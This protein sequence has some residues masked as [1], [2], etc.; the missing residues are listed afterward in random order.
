MAEPEINGF[1]S[2]PANAGGVSALTQNQ[3]LASQLF[4]YRNVLAREVGELRGLAR[5]RRPQRLP[6]VLTREEV[7]QVWARLS[8]ADRLMASLLYGPGFRLNKCLSLRVQHI[9]FERRPLLVRDSNGGKDRLTMLP[10]SLVEALE[11]HLMHVRAVLG[12]RPL[13]WLG[14][15]RAAR[16]DGA[17]VSERA[18]G[19]A[20]AMGVSAGEA[21]AQR[22]V[23]RAGPQP[24]RRID[25]VNGG[26][27]GSHRVRSA[28]ASELP[29]LP[30]FVRHLSPR[31]W[32]RHPHGAET[33]GTQRS[34]D[35]DDL[36]LCAESRRPGREEHSGRCASRRRET[37]C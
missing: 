34:A 23:R 37:L 21:L 18:G 14:A 1:L 5:A 32:L 29:Q 7:R 36:H 16:C 26:A 17:K 13:R 8:G 31:S 30:S 4:P 6:V 11:R 28:Q 22:S 33:A 20:M 12:R 24:C 27:S 19:V 3:A 10:P 35:G 15:G 9:D 2:H 25:L